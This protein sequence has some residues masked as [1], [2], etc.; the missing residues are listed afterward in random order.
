[1]HSLDPFISIFVALALTVQ[2]IVYESFNF[3]ENVLVLRLLPW[4]WS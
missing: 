4:F 2:N 3:P 1:M